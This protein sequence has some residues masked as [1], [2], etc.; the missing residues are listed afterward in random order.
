MV[1][2][3][4][5]LHQSTRGQKVSEPEI[6]SKHLS[7]K[8]TVEFHLQLQISMSPQNPSGTHQAPT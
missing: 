4:I 5:S 6:L 7:G 8:A 1:I 2:I 3:S